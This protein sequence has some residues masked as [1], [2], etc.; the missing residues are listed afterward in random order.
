[1][2]T[3]RATFYRYGENPVSSWV[4]S[5]FQAPDLERAVARIN[6][7]LRMLNRLNDSKEKWFLKQLNEHGTFSLEE[8]KQQ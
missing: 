3:W 7:E 8:L 6:K 1:M 4:H 5:T 2:K